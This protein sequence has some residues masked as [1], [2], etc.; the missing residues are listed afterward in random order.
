MM[1]DDIVALD[2]SLTGSGW[3]NGRKHGVIKP[4]RMGVERLA[5]IRA[6]VENIVGENRAAGVVLEGYAFGAHNKAHQIGELGG[7]IRLLLHD[8]G[9][10]FVEVPPKSLKKFATGT[11]N[12]PKDAMIA[13]AIRTF[14]FD[15]SDNNEAD[16]WLLWHMAQYALGDD[17]GRRTIKRDEAV[18][19][20]EWGAI[21]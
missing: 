1:R 19:A 8:L 9:V 18:A 20:V 10:P 16:A 4:K 21:R 13:H 3:A 11:G 2:L 7:V 6:T 5:F 12:A 14:G 15:G 17:M